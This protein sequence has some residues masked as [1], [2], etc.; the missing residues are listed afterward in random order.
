MSIVIAIL[1]LAGWLAVVI[2]TYMK[3]I[4]I[5]KIEESLKRIEKKLEQG[6]K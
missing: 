3:L 4:Q 5:D 6:K 1:S 2:V